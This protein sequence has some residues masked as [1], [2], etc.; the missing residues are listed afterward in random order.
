MFNMNIIKDTFNEPEW[1]YMVQKKA[2]STS[3]CQEGVP[4]QGGQLREK[5]RVVQK[6]EHYEVTS[7]QVSQNWLKSRVIPPLFEKS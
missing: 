6:E 3:Q 2:L 4:S 1:E 7:Q 5:Y